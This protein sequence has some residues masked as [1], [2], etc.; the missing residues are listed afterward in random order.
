MGVSEIKSLKSLEKTNR[1]LKTMVAGFMLDNTMLKD[2][3]S[4]KW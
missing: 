2:V 3:N 1:K 4:K